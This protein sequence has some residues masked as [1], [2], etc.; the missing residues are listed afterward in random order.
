MAES[1]A[2]PSSQS[3]TLFGWMQLVRLPTVFT[4]LADVSGAYLLVAGAWFPRRVLR[5]FCWQAF[6]C[7]GRGWC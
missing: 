5:W 4:I 7:I 6:V 2:S 3:P 1:A